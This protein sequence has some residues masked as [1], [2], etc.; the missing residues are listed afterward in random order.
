MRQLILALALASPLGACA[1]LPTSG[2]GDAA[3]LLKAAN[4]HI[5]SCERHY[6]GGLGVGAAFTFRIDCPAVSRT[7]AAPVAPQG[8]GG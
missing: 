4:E 3:E 5:E 2:K 8:A 7:P 6:Q 1:G